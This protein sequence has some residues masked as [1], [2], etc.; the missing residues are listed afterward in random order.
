MIRHTV[1]FKFKENN[2]LTISRICADVKQR[3]E[4]LPRKI[5]FIKH[6]VCGVDFLH[7]LKSFDLVLQV[8]FDSVD[9]LNKYQTNPSHLEIAMFMQPY[10]TE[11]AVVDFN[12]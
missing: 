11:A 5:T 12:F 3:F 6:L 4:E 1:F 7:S 8:D 9:D 2:G 10:K